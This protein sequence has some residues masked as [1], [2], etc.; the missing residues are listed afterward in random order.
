[1]GEVAASEASWSQ[2]DEGVWHKHNLRTKIMNFRGLDSNIILIL[3]R[4]QGIT[5]K[6]VRQQILVGIILVGRLGVLVR[7]RT[8]SSDTDPL[9]YVYI[10]IY[11]YMCVCIIYIYIYIYVYT[12]VC[13]YVYIYIYIYIY[14]YTLYIYIMIVIIIACSYAKSPY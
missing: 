1:M 5:R 8:R 4:P 3:R 2:T 11:M 12:H 10:Y 14:V 6:A 9:A 7:V 13:M